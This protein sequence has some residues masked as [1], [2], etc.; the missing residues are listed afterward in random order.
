M[1]SHIVPG[2]SLCFCSW[3]FCV[4][5]ALCV[6]QAD[7]SICYT[8]CCGSVFGDK[9]G[10]CQI[11]ISWRCAYF[12]CIPAENLTCPWLAGKTFG[13]WMNFMKVPMTTVTCWTCVSK[14]ELCIRVN[15]IV[16]IYFQIG[17]KSLI[18]PY[19]NHLKGLSGRFF[20]I[21]PS[22]KDNQCYFVQNLSTW[23][24]NGAGKILWSLDT[25]VGTL[26]G[27]LDHFW[28][29]VSAR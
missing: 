2:R 21:V 11:W 26:L 25:L 22:W 6:K 19:W 12:K 5:T 8:V 17:N 7:S 27:K 18:N 23:I 16:V 9:L 14:A 10:S 3:I 4:H 28:P 15:V 1:F 29:S 13:L 20:M 24:M